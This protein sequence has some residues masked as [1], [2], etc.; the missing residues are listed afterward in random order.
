MPMRFALLAALI[1]VQSLAAQ[2]D[3]VLFRDSSSELVVVPVTVMDKHGGLVSDLNKDRFAVYDDRKRGDIAFFTN[4]DTPVSVA[5]VIDCSGSMRHKMGE[6]L[7]ATMA[8]A[9]SSHP[10]DELLV[11]GFNDTVEDALGGR[12]IIAE[13]VRELETALQ[14]LVADG[15]TALYS[16]LM[17]ALDH[18][19]RSTYARK[20]IVLISDG[21]DNASDVPLDRVLDRA[22]RSNATIYSIGLFDRDDPETNPGVLKRIAEATGGERYLP[23]SG[24]RLLAVCE[25]IAQEIRNSYTLGIVP[26]RRD[27]RFHKLRVEV[28]AADGRHLSVRARPGYQAGNV[29]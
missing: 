19:E 9:R 24:G 7:V 6:V 14:S 8:F 1:A 28:S 13:N 4:E 18:L 15:R 12:P 3:Q 2:D 16:G 23:E 25:R 26:S 20:V 27:G 10:E 29:R 5:L 11:I 17:D 22:Q 21:G